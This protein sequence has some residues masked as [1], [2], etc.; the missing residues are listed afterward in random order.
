VGPRRSLSVAGLDHAEGARGLVALAAG[1]GYRAITL[2]A[3][4]R[5]VRPRELDRS[6]RRE[7][8]ALLRRHALDLSGLD[9][10]VPRAHWQAPATQDRALSA[11][12]QAIE[13][14]AELA[15]LVGGSSRAVVSVEVGEVAESLRAEIAAAESR[16]G[17]LAADHARPPGLA[18]VGIDPAA[19]L[20]AGA[21]P[22]AEV[23]GLAAPPVSARMSDLGPLGRVRAG[24]G[25]LDVQAY[26]A[27]L[28]TRGYAGDLVV[29]VRG[30]A[31][32]IEA[33]RAAISGPSP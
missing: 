24:L 12:A 28:V 6:G 30:V 8:A 13:L 33:A 7:I 2:D 14:A 1:L 18:G 29:D 19:L 4:A 25:R 15:R 23:V 21:D 10:W 9:L 16:A 27:V 32:P 31:Q 20:A 3:T 22:V 17:G 11:L 26:E 5:G